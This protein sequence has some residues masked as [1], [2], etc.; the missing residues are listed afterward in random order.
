MTRNAAALGPRRA[1]HVLGVIEF[2]IE[3]LFETAG[4]SLPRG[5]V[6]V[7][8]RVTDRTH[9]HIRRR[10]LSQVTSGAVFVTRE[11]RLG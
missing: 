6:A 4:K 1:G 9:R 10:K 3:A 8:T 11:D 5:V 7:H 2:Q